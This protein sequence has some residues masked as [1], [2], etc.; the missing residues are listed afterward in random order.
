MRSGKL[1][2]LGQGLRWIDAGTHPT[3][4]CIIN[5][6]NRCVPAS[7]TSWVKVENGS[8]P[9]RTLPLTVLLTRAI[10]AFRQVGHLGSKLKMA[11]CRDAPYR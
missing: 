1:D 11:R 7:W 5:P 4:G 8:M 10:G 3:I 6:G 9:G 2:I